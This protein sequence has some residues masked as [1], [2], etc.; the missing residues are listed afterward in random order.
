MFST[1]RTS[2]VLL[3]VIALLP[4]ALSWVRGRAL[5]R[6]AD[7]PLLPER[8]AATRR[9]NGAA[10]GVACVILLVLSTRSAVWTM[11]LLVLA[12]LAA[13]Y[14]SRRALFGETWSITAYLSFTLR[15]Y[16]VLFGF[17]MLLA[18]APSVARLAGGSDWLAGFVLGGVLLAWN[19]WYAEAVRWCL[20]TRPLE[21]GPLLERC[22]ALARRCALTV[23]R[24]ERVDLGGGV[25]ANA[26]ALPSLRGSSVLFTDTLLA[27]LTE[28]E[29][30][31]I[32]AHELAH[33]EYYDTRRLRRL[34]AGT[35]ALIVTASAWPALMRAAE[36]ASAWSV[37]GWLGILVTGLVMRGRG[38]QRQETMS[39]VRAVELTS[40]AEALV[41]A[42]TK[43]YAT[44]R[45]PRR[46]EL[47][48]ERN[49]THPSLAR[50]IRDIRK[51][52]GE[53]GGGLQ[54]EATF[55]SPGGLSS[56]TF[57]P[58]SVR[59]SRNAAVHHSVE[60]GQLTE[61]RIE[62]AAQGEAR[63]VL[64]GPRVER[65]ELV[66]RPEDVSRAQAL[67][68]AVDGRLCEP[69]AP[70]QLPP[71]VGRMA[72]TIAALLALSGGQIAVAIVAF[73]AVARPAAPLL[74]AASLASAAAAALAVADT[75]FHPFG[76]VRVLPAVLAGI[77]FLVLAYTKRHDERPPLG[78]SIVLLT[79]LAALSLGSL[80]LSGLDA[81]GLHQSAHANP[82][83]VIFFVALGGALACSR[84]RR[85][86]VAAFG[87]VVIAALAGFAA[88]PV[89]LDTFGRDPL[90][91]DGP[92]LTRV[93]IAA[94]MLDEV[95]VPAIASRLQL[96]PGGTHIAVREE[97]HSEEVRTATY[98]VGA[99]GAR[100]T[101]IR[102]DDLLFVDDR[103]LLLAVSD[104]AGTMLREVMSEAPH[105]V[106][107]EQRVGDVR[108]GRLSFTG[109]T[110]RWRITGWNGQGALVRAEGT[111]GTS[112]VGRSEWPDSSGDDGWI[113]AFTTVGDRALVLETRYDAAP[114][115][116]L[117]PARWQWTLLLA[118][119]PR[120]RLQYAAIGPDGREVLA[121]SRLAADCDAALLRDEALLCAVFD[122]TRTRL[123]S[124]DATGRI[125]ALGWFYG[126]FVADDN[127]VPGWL[128]G[129][130]GSTPV[131]IRLGTR[132]MIVLRDPTASRI[133]VSGDRLAALTW[134]GRSSKLRT[135][136]V[137]Q[138]HGDSATARLGVLPE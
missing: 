58:S 41:R 117:V 56:V 123:V 38:K 119:M 75:R 121:T 100:L 81:V 76:L 135:Y 32:C 93:P 103:H 125:G 9:R 52:G 118:R 34:N 62:A 87:A 105:D 24:M 126:T 130:A 43:L 30:A 46:V 79:L 134:N 39:D 88:S 86:Q 113:E 132:D 3:A 80:G 110:R 112:S 2:P 69:G 65:Q 82:S 14:P 1:L 18:A 68:D 50:R 22:R 5:M 101:A 94:V 116:S 47:Q 128:T 89:F 91:V 45:I 66:L 61:L 25:I 11:P 108:T 15:L 40:D 64:A 10:F 37:L 6:L 73:I 4:A 131:A 55:G 54:D 96:S 122:G 111:L 8:L 59:W 51:A 67:L 129:W 72:A 71:R 74:L 106:V 20:A 33:L 98:H 26:L 48:R 49:D 137:Q 127:G 23:P 124:I 17:W 138:P 83:A 85:T 27:R 102:G 78:A 21:D 77:V 13:A 70:A 7:D 92:R 44:A 63:L 133:A 29:V 97:P 107:W 99:A 53:T 104:S 109:A 16:F 60:Y 114:F 95:D 90:L 36:V 120:M 19:H 136:A 42:L 31:A 84:V 28:N 57:G 35:I 12:L 115:D